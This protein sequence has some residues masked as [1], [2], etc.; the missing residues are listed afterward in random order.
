MDTNSMKLMQINFLV[1][2]KK[3][4]LDIYL[5]FIRSTHHATSNF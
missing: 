4:I 5:E 2:G 3:L 1:L